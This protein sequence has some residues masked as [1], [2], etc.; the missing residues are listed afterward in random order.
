M[1]NLGEVGVIV[2]VSVGLGVDVL[3]PGSRSVGKYQDG[4]SGKRP[5]RSINM[6]IR[7]AFVYRGR[8]DLELIFGESERDV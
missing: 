5:R 1:S 8:I 6:I 7:L 3:F 4:S 2:L